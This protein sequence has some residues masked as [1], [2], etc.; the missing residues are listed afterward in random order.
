MRRSERTAGPLSGQIQHYVYE[1]NFLDGYEDYNSDDTN[2]E[3]IDETKNVTQRV[4]A[5]GDA[6]T[7]E[8]R[9]FIIEIKNIDTCNL[10]EKRSQQFRFGDYVYRLTKL[11]DNDRYSDKSLKG[12]IDMLRPIE[13]NRKSGG[14]EKDDVPFVGRLVDFTKAVIDE[15]R[16]ESVSIETILLFNLLHSPRAVLKRDESDADDTPVLLGKLDCSGYDFPS[17][18]RYT[19]SVDVIDLYETSCKPEALLKRLRHPS[20]QEKSKLPT[21]NKFMTR[22]FLESLKIAKSSIR[23]NDNDLLKQYR[24][25]LSTNR[26]VVG[27]RENFKTNRMKIDEDAAIV[28]SYPALRRTLIEDTITKICKISLAV[29]RYVATR[30]RGSMD[31][32]NYQYPCFLHFDCM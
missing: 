23:K 29:E 19:M 13:E 1:Q 9:S 18:T 27:D 24:A 4:P 15:P 16:L 32:E 26:N 20:Y 10:F 21:I 30:S 2:D 7:E 12:I 6:S 11:L 31:N 5:N 22:S 28:Q 17:R 25:F 8:F 3:T 14:K